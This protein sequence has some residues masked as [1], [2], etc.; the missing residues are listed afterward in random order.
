MGSEAMN[1]KT[2]DDVYGGRLN[3]KK[4]NINHTAHQCA[5][6][7]ACEHLKL[8]WEQGAQSMP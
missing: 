2:E 3:L 7:C 5:A 4:R 6:T 8:E 1:D